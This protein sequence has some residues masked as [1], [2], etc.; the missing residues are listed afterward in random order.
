LGITFTAISV[1]FTTL[2]PSTGTI[3]V[4]WLVDVDTW[5]LLTG[6]P[7]AVDIAGVMKPVPVM[8]MGYDCPANQTLGEIEVMVG[9]GQAI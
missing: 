2:V 8:V 4:D 7:V 3:N 5:T 9:M 1:E 6:Q